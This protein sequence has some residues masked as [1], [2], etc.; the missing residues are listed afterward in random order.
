MSWQRIIKELAY[1]D[2]WVSSKYLC[3]ILNVSRTAVWKHIKFLKN[4]NFK[5][6]C[7]P[8]KGY[9]L[10]FPKDTIL[11]VS[12]DQLKSYTFCPQLMSFISID[13][14]NNY[15]KKLDFSQIKEGMIVIAESQTG[16]KGRKGRTWFSPFGK[17]LYFS[18][19]LMPRLPVYIIPRLTIVAG[20]S[21]A[22]ALKNFNIDVELKWPNDLIISD[23]KIGGILSEL[24]S[25]GEDVQFV[26]LG[27][28]INVNISLKDFPQEIKNIAGSIYSTTG[29]IIDRRELFLKI[30]ED[31]SFR[32]NNFIK[33]GGEL[34][35]IKEIWEEIAFGK[36]RDFYI[37]TGNEKE[38][39]RVVGLKED[40]A[41]IANIKG[42]TKYIYAG[43]IL[44]NS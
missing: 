4:N 35:E 28:G 42:E 40:G 10:L 24:Y 36:D 9:K 19:A 41:L 31:F 12:E 14:T 15:I 1:K 33:S 43:E 5:I 13:S 30:F 37:T 11:T 25:E 32:Y 38:L 39:G 26:I 2:D 8:K 29:K 27:V 3:E 6:E 16:G 18:I 23:R 20:V 21:V 17:N 7:C 44:L 22:M 34:S